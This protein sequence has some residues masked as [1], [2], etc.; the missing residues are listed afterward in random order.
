MKTR[1]SSLAMIITLMTGCSD[2]PI[3]ETLHDKYWL[4]VSEVEE[5]FGPSSKSTQDCEKDDV[6][7][8]DLSGTY[9]VTSGPLPCT[10]DDPASGTVE[11][12]SW[13]GT[14]EPSDLNDMGQ[15]KLVRVTSTRLVTKTFFSGLPPRI[16]EYRAVAKPE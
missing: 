16:R 8:F 4:L 11:T 1:L 2:R 10:P 6:Y 14:R 9:T 5:G 13:L 15:Q 3:E 12:F 7:Q